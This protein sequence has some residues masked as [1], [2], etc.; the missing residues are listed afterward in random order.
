MR[1]RIVLVG[2]LAPSMFAYREL[3]IRYKKVSLGE[4]RELAEGAEVINFVRHEATVKLLSSALGRDLSPNPGLYQ[5]REGDVL[6]VIGLRKPVRGQEVE[7]KPDD[8]DIALCR[9]E[10]V[11]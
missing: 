7:V 5:W 9:V 4:L 6:V 1:H 3:L 8:L 10:V 2:G 11:Q